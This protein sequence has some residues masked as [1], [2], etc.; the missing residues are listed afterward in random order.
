MSGRQSGKGQDTA[1]CTT[2]V[3]LLP[4]NPF[5]RSRPTLPCLT[6]SSPQGFVALRKR[7]SKWFFVEEGP[8]SEL[9][10]DVHNEKRTR[11]GR[12]E[13]RLDRAMTAQNGGCRAEQA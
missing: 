12:A 9:G 11:R 5:S 7:F 3:K 1:Y 4:R 2:G 8:V 10:R 13:L 6:R